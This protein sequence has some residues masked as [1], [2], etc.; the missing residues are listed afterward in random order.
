[1]LDGFLWDAVLSIFF[2]YQLKRLEKLFSGLSSVG[3][4][5]SFASGMVCEVV[6]VRHNVTSIIFEQVFCH[7]AGAALVLVE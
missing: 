6:S 5:N 4:A 7:F 3:K 2:V 1:M